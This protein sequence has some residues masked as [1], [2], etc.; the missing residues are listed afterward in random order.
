MDFPY[1]NQFN[2]N[3]KELFSKLQL[4]VI[5][6]WRQLATTTTTTTSFLFHQLWT[7]VH[8]GNRKMSSIQESTLFYRTPLQNI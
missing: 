4:I 6:E 5:V 7:A 3:Y 1:L 8:H 2:L